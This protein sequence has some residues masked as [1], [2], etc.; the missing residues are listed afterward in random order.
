M[1]IPV[2]PVLTRYGVMPSAM[3]LPETIK[4]LAR[5]NA[6]KIDSGSKKPGLEPKGSVSMADVRKIA[7]TK[8]KDLNATTIDAAA[9]I[10]AGS[11]RSMGL[12]VKE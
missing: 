5:L 4:G 11:A 10:I 1:G 12:S 6:A 3:E 8:M 7:E 2:I 9:K